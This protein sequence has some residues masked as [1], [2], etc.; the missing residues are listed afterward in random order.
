MCSGKE[1]VDSHMALLPLLRQEPRDRIFFLC[2]MH[3]VA[4]ARAM[5]FMGKSSSSTSE[6]GHGISIVGNFFKGCS[7][8]VSSSNIADSVPRLLTVSC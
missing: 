6:R 2:P 3:A 4:R 8:G 1:N 5:P 7:G